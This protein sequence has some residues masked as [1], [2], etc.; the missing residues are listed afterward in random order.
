VS[1][2]SRASHTSRVTGFAFR[3]AGAIVFGRGARD[4]VAEAA[5]RFGRRVLLVTGARSLAAGGE[6][7][8]MSD[9]FSSAG[10]A[11]ATWTVAGEPDVDVVDRGAA[12][13]A[14]SGAQVVVA[15]GGGSVLDAAKAI[16]AVATSGGSAID[17]LEDLP[18]AGG[19]ALEAPPLP[20]VAVPTTAGT[21]SE[22]TRNAVVRVPQAALKRSMRDDR[23]LPAFAIVD[24]DLSATAPPG[25]A[26]AAALDALTHLV[27]S[28]ASLGAQP[29][30]DLFALEGARRAAS[31][32]RELA[33]RIEEDP[34]GGQ[35]APGARDAALWNVWD[36]LAL[37]SLWGGMALANAGLGAVHGLAAPLGGRCAIPHG[38]ACAALLAPTVRANVVALRA[39]SPEAPALARYGVLA[40]AISASDD[41]LRLA[42]DLDVLRRRLGA[43]PLDAFGARPDDVSAVVAGA[44]GGSMKNNPIALTD[45][46]LASILGAAMAD[47]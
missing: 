10:L 23:M 41:P 17:Y 22:V 3:T 9:R 15:V 30:T 19:R 14:A 18:G 7:E 27:E 36:E 25:V 32:L 46:E 2:V 21:G 40:R 12:T 5:H 45:V 35:A 31:A 28:Y 34:A 39:R 38:A 11:V 6:L 47:A 16:A 42:D 37:A 13:A 43:R 4:R 8:R 33:A 26:V 24:P 29:T 44:R 20:V 1:H